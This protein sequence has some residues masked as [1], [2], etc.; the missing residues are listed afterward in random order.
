MDPGTLLMVAAIV[1]VAVLLILV[2]P[3]AQAAHGVPIRP[4][5]VYLR[6]FRDNR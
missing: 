1:A 3:G 2:R 6:A 4:G 5:G